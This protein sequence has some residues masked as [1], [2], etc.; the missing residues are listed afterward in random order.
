LTG[1][2]Q[3]LISIIT[4]SLN[5]V[6]FIGNAI[7]SVILQDFDGV[8]HIIMDGGSTDGTLE[9]LKNYPH[10]RVISQ[11]DNGLYDA[12]NQGIA[13]AKGRIIGLLNTDDYYEPNIFGMVE[14]CFRDNKEI[15]AISGSAVLFLEDG[16]GQQA[17]LRVFPSIKPEDLLF[18]VTRGTPII[19]AWFFQKDFVSMVGPFDT[20]YRYSA[21]RDWMIRMANINPAFHSLNQLVYHYRQHPGSL[22]LDGVYNPEARDKCESIDIALEHSRNP[23]ISKEFA[24]FLRDWYADMLIARIE[25]SI[26]RFDFTGAFEYFLEGRENQLHWPTILFYRTWKRMT[27]GCK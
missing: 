10:L 16:N 4:P 15:K 21:D 25:N 18:R 14:K 8:E 26:K 3:H 19:N 13:L 6:N 20:R 22:T 24:G 9:L 1:Q 23:S 11:K 7:R 27:E 17:D 12:L 5:R 2:N